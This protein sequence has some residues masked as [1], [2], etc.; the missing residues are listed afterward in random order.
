MPEHEAEPDP[1]RPLAERVDRY[2]LYQDAVQGPHGDIAFFEERFEETRGRS[3]L[4]LRE[5]FAGTCLLSATWVES[6]GERTALALD[7]DPEPLA[8]GWQ[9]NLENGEHPTA[10]RLQQVVGDVREHH[11]DDFDIVCAMNFSFC[12]LERREELLDYLATAYGSL[13][14]DGMLVLELCGGTELETTATEEREIEGGTYIWEQ[15]AFNP[16]NHRLTCYI[17]F[18]LEDGSRLDRAF[19]YTWRLW[20]I[21]EV[22]ELLAEAGFASSEVWWETV[23]E[24]GEGTGEYRLTEEE[25][26]QESWLVYIVGYR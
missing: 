1:P 14:E 5:D 17:H 26:N 15:A 4:H 24:D 11:G 2:R 22:R 8:W 9:Y 21:P 16:I 10:K 23:D 25:E 18:D 12:I 7:H 3:P 20:S 6:D 19:E 13:V